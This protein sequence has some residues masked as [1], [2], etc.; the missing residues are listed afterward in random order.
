MR[1]ITLPSHVGESQN[2]HFLLPRE[3]SQ[4]CWYF[5]DGG[6][7]KDAGGTVGRTSDGWRG[8]RERPAAHVP[9][10]TR[11]DARAPAQSTL[12]SSGDWGSLPR[13]TPMGRGRLGSPCAVRRHPHIQT[14]SHPA[15]PWDKSLQLCEPSRAKSC[16]LEGSARAVPGGRLGS[17][18]GPRSHSPSELPSREKA[19]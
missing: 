13:V 6:C 14:C 11:E 17:D 18:A 8:G 3:Q 7:W 4:C 16:R 1:M 10:A 2:G 15:L 9:H 19:E 12:P 5:L